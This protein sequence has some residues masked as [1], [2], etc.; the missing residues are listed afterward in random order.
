MKKIIIISL[1]AVLFQAS[2]LVRA[3]DWP[4]EYLGLPGD[5]LNLYAVM[6]LFQESETLEGFERRLNDENSRINNLDLNGDNLVDYLAVYD[7]VNGDIH[8][9]VLRSVLSRN[10]YQDVAVFTVERFPN[11]SVQIQLIGDEALYGRNYIIEPIYAETPNPGYIGTVHNR[12]NVTIATTSYYEVAA[13]PL[14]RFIFFPGYVVWRS[15]W[16]W[17][18]YP[19]YWKP[20]HPFYWHFYYGYHYN[21]Y[22]HYY[23]YYRHWDHYRCA[24]YNNFYY[25]SR[26]MFSPT[27]VININKGN[28]KPTYSRPE[29]RHSGEILFAEMHPDRYAETLNRRTANNVDRNPVVSRTVPATTVTGNSSGAQGRTATTSNIKPGNDNTTVRTT[30]SLN[31]PTIAIQKRNA[32]GTTSNRNTGNIIKSTTTV[33]ERTT[34]RQVSVRTSE[35]NNTKSTPSV[36]RKTTVSASSGSSNAAAVRSSG[37]TSNRRTSSQASVKSTASSVMKSTQSARTASVSDKNKNNNDN[38]GNSRNPRR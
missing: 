33:S 15:A 2:S 11:G 21:W 31:N 25:S 36:S 20:W 32:S 16:Y 37:N 7:Y 19:V 1:L 28:Y 10:E 5:N 12:T 38:S 24:W 18:Y 30:E 14:I 17:D 9:I 23:R 22:A 6:K 13:W 26:R 4:E 34:P 29:Q 27:V 8:T 3:Q 35:V